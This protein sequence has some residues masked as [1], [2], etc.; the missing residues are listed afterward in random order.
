MQITIAIVVGVAILAG[1]LYAIFGRKDKSFNSNAS[2]SS[3]SG[4]GGESPRDQKPR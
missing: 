1:I 3:G 4:S 2:G